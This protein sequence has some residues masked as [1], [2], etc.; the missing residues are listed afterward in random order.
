MILIS[1]YNIH[2]DQ[3]RGEGSGHH[4]CHDG[5]IPQSQPNYVFLHYGTAAVPYHNGLESVHNGPQRNKYPPLTQ[6]RPRPNTH[7]LL[8]RLDAH[9]SWTRPDAHPPHPTTASTTFQYLISA[10]A[11][12]RNTPSVLKAQCSHTS[13]T[14]PAWRLWHYTN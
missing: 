4:G 13:F 1:P 8:P 10:T 12:V 6:P 5:R 2:G 3:G 7:P 9:P 11:T 14:T